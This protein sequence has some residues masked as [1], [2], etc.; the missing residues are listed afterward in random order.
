MP[1][2]PY[3]YGETTRESLIEIHR[4][5]S[6][7]I[8]Y[9]GVK[10]HKRP[11]RPPRADYDPGGI[12]GAEGPCVCAFPQPLRL[13]LNY[14]YL[15]RSSACN[16]KVSENQAIFQRCTAVNRVIKNKTVTEE[17][18]VFLSPIMDQLTIIGKVMVLEIQG[19]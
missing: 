14:G 13:P 7:N 3:I 12:S 2:L 18:Q 5:I 11:A 19:N 17:Q 16:R 8:V 6:G 9:G 1:I 15:P 4:L 10:L